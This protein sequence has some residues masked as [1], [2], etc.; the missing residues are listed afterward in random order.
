ME[1][2]CTWGS[3]SGPPKIVEKGIFLSTGEQKK[4]MLGLFGHG[5]SG[6]VIQI[7]S[8]DTREVSSV[9]FVL[10]HSLFHRNGFKLLTACL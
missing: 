8:K 2:D 3:L 6:K 5:E 7:Q 10:P 9:F 4:K 1:W